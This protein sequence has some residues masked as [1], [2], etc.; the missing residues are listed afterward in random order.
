M[1][2]LCLGLHGVAGVGAGQSRDALDATLHVR[3]RTDAAGAIEGHVHFGIVGD[4]APHAGHPALVE[5]HAAPGFIARLAFVGDQHVAPQFLAR[6]GIVARDVATERRF[7]ATGARDHHAIDHD[8]PGGVGDIIIAA[9]VGFPHQLAGLCV[10]GDNRVVPGDGVDLVFI[11]KDAALALAPMAAQG[12]AR[13]QGA[14][15]LPEQFAG[16]RIQRLNNV[17]GIAQEHHAFVDDGRGFIDARLHQ[18]RPD[19]LQTLHIG[20]VDL[21]EGAEPPALIIAAHHDP[22]GRIGIAQHRVGDGLVFGQR[23]RGRR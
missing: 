6:P 17:A 2:L 1:I 16:G 22:V 5:W 10:Q 12:F 18:P 20:L 23:V 7:L 11:Q 4:R 14:A 8:R 13:G 9:T 21:V 19:E 15:V 3:G